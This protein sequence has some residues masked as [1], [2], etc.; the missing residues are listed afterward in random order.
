MKLFSWFLSVL[1]EMILQCY[2]SQFGICS[3]DMNPIQDFVMLS[4]S[5]LPNLWPL[6]LPFP[7][8]LG[9][10]TPHLFPVPSSTGGSI[11]THGC[12]QYVVTALLPWYSGSTKW[13]KA[14]RTAAQ[15]LDKVI[16]ISCIQGSPLLTLA[17]YSITILV[18]KPSICV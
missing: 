16:P 11:I 17:Y 10:P 13:L 7:S 4:F 8:S 2:D 1:K 6:R 14:A 18:S 15:F 3:A 12:H 9:P 5:N